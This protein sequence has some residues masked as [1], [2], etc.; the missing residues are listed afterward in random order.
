MAT[1]R[2]RNNTKGSMRRPRKIEIRATE[3]AS[4]AFALIQGLIV[5]FGEG[6]TIAELFETVM[7]P[8]LREYVK[9]YAEK[10][11]AERSAQ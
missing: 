8:A 10:A 2:K 6:D 4:N 5:A 1:V 7:L 9:P 11:K 3:R